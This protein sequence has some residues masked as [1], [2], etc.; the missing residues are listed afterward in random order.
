[1]LY[2]HRIVWLVCNG[3]LDASM[4]ASHPILIFD[5][6]SYAYCH[7]MVGM[8]PPLGMHARQSCNARPEPL[9][10]YLCANRQA[11]QRIASVQHHRCLLRMPLAHGRRLGRAQRV[12]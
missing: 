6:L 3:L 5:C 8:T 12:V 10:V 11:G 2:N 7:V 9:L 1:M 4:R